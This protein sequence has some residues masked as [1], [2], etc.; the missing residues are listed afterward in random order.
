M[1][2][3]RSRNLIPLLAVLSVGVVASGTDLQAQNNTVVELN[4]EGGRPVAEAV[5]LLEAKYGW[6]ITYEDPRYAH[7]SDIQDVA[8]R[9]RK[10]LAQFRP[11]EAPKVLVPKGGQVKM[12]YSVSAETGRPEDPAALLQTLLD[13]Q[14]GGGNRFRL[15][16][17]GEVFHVLPAWVKNSEGRLVEQGSI[18]DAAITLPEKERVGVHML[19]AICDAVSRATQTHVEVGIIPTNLFLQLRTKQ[20]ASNQ[21]ARDVL[22]DTLAATKRKIS[23]HL[24]YDPGMKWYALNLHFVPNVSPVAGNPSSPPANPKQPADASPARR[25]KP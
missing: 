19:Q 18:L 17:N 10:D 6:V 2:K 11:G 14:A 15:A 13:I 23:W 24:Y 3:K 12:S 22:L 7:E 1:C 4:V 20:G 5:K 25:S 9:V 8:Y 21:T 16:Q